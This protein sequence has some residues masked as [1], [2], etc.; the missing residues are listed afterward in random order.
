[1]SHHLEWSQW[2]VKQVHVN[3][4]QPRPERSSLYSVC[5]CIVKYAEFVFIR[6]RREK[7]KRNIDCVITF[8]VDATRKKLMFFS[9]VMTA[10]ATKTLWP[11][12]LN[13]QTCM[14]QFCRIRRSPLKHKWTFNEPLCSTQLPQVCMDVPI[15]LTNSNKPQQETHCWFVCLQKK[16][17]LKMKGL[18]SKRQFFGLLSSAWEQWMEPVQRG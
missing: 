3:C 12:C 15:I 6:T 5:M 17:G 18:R 2:E 1:M 7:I 4:S 8:Q 11:L 13:R 14:M 10:E 16:Q 9:P